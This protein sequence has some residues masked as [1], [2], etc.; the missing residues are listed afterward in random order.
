[1]R[2][3]YAPKRFFDLYPAEGGN[4]SVPRLAP[5]PT[6]PT[7]V[8]AVAM[9]NWQVLQWCSGSKDV[10]CGPLS[11][12]FPLDNTTVAPDAAAYMRRSY[13]ASTSWTDANIG[14]VLDAFE[15]LA[16]SA[17][18]LMWGD[19]GWHLGDLDVW[20]KM[21]NF[22]HATRIPFM[23]RIPGVA[24]GRVPA[25]VEALDIFPTVVMEALGADYA[26][27]PCPSKAS[28]SRVT[29]LCTEGRT[30]SSLLRTPSNTTWSTA[31][32]SQFPR[33]EHP[34]RPDLSCKPKEPCPNKMGYS[35]RVD[36]FRCARTLVFHR[37]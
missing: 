27:P 24:P 7:N 15:P 3:R 20:A 22:E 19:H 32:Y 1:M 23:M 26:I 5:H 14:R 33:P 16:S 9:Q 37:A 28:A 2:T 4:A 6:L 18:V 34:A 35:V 10:N 11:N 29:A 25:L 21:T 17:I 12:A 31:A 30:L 8:P 13:W 36:K